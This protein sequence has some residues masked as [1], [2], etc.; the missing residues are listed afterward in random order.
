LKGFRLA[1]HAP[2]VAQSRVLRK[3]IIAQ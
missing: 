2:I 3:Y 1:N